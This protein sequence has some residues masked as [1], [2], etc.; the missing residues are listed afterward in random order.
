[1]NQKEAM[2]I[3]ILKNRNEVFDDIK[4]EENLGR[5]IFGSGLTIL[6]F[7]AI[8]GA[9]MGLF[10]GGFVII[11]DMIKIPLLL[12]LSL[13]LSSPSYFVIGA[14]IGL[15]IRFRQMLAILSVSY[16]VASTV[17]VSFTPVVFVYSVSESSNAIIHIV[18]YILFGL[19]GLCGGYYLLKGMSNTYG[20]E[21]EGILWILPFIIGGVLTF[22]V[23]IKL[24]W[25]LKP[26]FHYYQYFFEGLG[27]I[28]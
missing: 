26:Y 3:R 12:L 23:G 5:I 18:H 27:I 25:L 21:K 16:A 20:K 6:F 10:A 9:I 4:N 8:Y 11:M 14:L 1:M 22:L 24:V 28:L 7:S 13:Y 15:K 2:F 17:L 19:A